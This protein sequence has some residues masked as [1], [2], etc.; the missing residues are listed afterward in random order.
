LGK[1]LIADPHCSPQWAACSG[2][3]PLTDV[4]PVWCREVG[5]KD[6]MLRRTAWQRQEASDKVV[7]AQDELADGRA[8]IRSRCGVPALHSH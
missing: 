2:E 7:A 1:G 3:L 4:P 6:F 5:D 8:V